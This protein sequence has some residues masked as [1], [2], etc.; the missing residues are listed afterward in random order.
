[1]IEIATAV[2][3]DAAAILDL[4]KRAYQSEA[5][6]YNDWSLPPLT[7]SLES[8]QHEI[9]T[10]TVLKAVR[11]GVVVGSARAALAGEICAVGRLMVEPRLQG[12]GIGSALLHAV[13]ACFPAAGTFELFTGSRSLD[14]LRL[15]QRHGYV[16]SRREKV[17]PRLTLVFLRKQGLSAT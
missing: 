2:P 4:Q 16:E 12:Q 15:Y 11:E 10:I 7:Q 13:E 9:A 5:R 17:S 6:L 1:M 14:N 8:L 3:A